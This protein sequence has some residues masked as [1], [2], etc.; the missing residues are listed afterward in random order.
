M[1]NIIIPTVINAP[2]YNRENVLSEL[3]RAGAMR[4]L[5]AIGAIQYG[6]DNINNDLEILKRDIP[7]FRENGLEVGIWFWGLM[8]GGTP[9]FTRITGFNGEKRNEYMCPADNNFVEYM[10]EFV[11]KLASMSPDLILLDDDVRFGNLGEGFGCTCEHHLRLMSEILGENVIR[12][13]LFDKM[14][15]GKPN[16]YRST[17]MKVC[18]ESLENYCVKLREAVDSINPNVRLGLCACIS[19]YDT[20]GT[21]A[22][23]MS[24]LL[25]GNTKPY[26]RLIGAPYWGACRGWG[27][28]ISDVI[29]FE[30]QQ[31][32]RYTDTDIEI[33]PEGDP[34][35]RPR[36]AVPSSY[37]EIF[38]TA[39]RV[40]GGFSGIQK[41]MID[42]NSSA[43]YEKEYINRHVANK[44]IYEEIDSIF[45][46]KNAVGV[47]I[48]EPMK[49]LENADFT[50]RAHTVHTIPDMT[51]SRAFRFTSENSIPTVH[52]GSGECGISFGENIRAFI[53]DESIFKKPLVIDLPAARILMENGI[54]IGIKEFLGSASS[55]LE[56]FTDL[57][58]YAPS[59]PMLEK[60]T[61]NDNAKN[62]SY[63]ILDDKTE[64]PAAYT[65][66]NKN[67][68]KFLVYTFD[69]QLSHESVYRTYA[70]QK[71]FIKAMQ[72]F[73]VIFPVVISDCPDLY[74]IAK[75]DS[76]GN[77]AIG[78]WNCFA[79]GVY[80]KEIILNDTYRN[81]EIMNFNAE[82]LGNRILIKKLGAFEF[83][84]VNLTK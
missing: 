52:T 73:G 63:Y 16:K 32:S 50:N 59:Q 34:Y 54:D 3:K 22:F 42:Y 12:E 2:S 53:N 79:D 47:R 57:D 49:K 62:L 66:I 70:R 24:K 15:A 48:Y 29:E 83:G 51:F 78:L 1:H 27:H 30:R 19:N 58:E 5:L 84:F 55:K 77:M 39:L 33:V 80:E 72:E 75:K 7:Y 23:T 71:Q 36:Y 6:T 28:R 10:Q 31:R 11:R 38:D 35:P 43:F 25:A 60:V 61:L 68:A 8:M 13:G 18:G 40:S 41:Y 82:F 45:G 37:L 67:G 74:I 69:A 44:P 26:L 4:V 56:H 14:F 64:I 46:N 81:A 76:D 21:D 9:P 65:Y 17:F 20:D